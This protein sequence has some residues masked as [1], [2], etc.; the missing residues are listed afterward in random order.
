MGFSY[1][2]VGSTKAH[3]HTNGAGDGGAL[4]TTTLIDA[5]QLKS[6]ILLMGS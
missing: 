4:D 3:K 1:T 2:T 6:Q 5:S